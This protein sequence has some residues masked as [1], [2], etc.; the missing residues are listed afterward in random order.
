MWLLRESKGLEGGG[1]RERVTFSLTHYSVEKRKLILP[2]IVYLSIHLSCRRV[3]VE[4]MFGVL[5]M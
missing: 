3:S 5:Y 1:P 2:H 4:K